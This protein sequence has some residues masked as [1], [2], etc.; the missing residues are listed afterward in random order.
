[1]TSAASGTRPMRSIAAGWQ[2]PLRSAVAA[3]RSARRRRL[4]RP[5]TVRRRACPIVL[6]ARVVGDEKRIRFI[7]DLSAPVDAAVFTLADPYRIIVDLPEV[8][9]ALPE[10][11][12]SRGAGAGLG[13]P[14]RA[15]S[16]RASRASSS[17]SPGR[18]RSTS[19]SS[20]SRPTAS[21]RGW[22]STSCRRRARSFLEASAGLPRQ[23][24]RSR[25][26]KRDRELVA[27][28]ATATGRSIVLDP[29]HGGI[30]TGAKGDGGTLEKDVVLA[31][32]QGA[33]REARRRPAAI[34][35]VYTRNDDSFVALGE[36]VAI[37]R[38]PARRAVRLDPRQFVP[39]GSRC[40]APSSTRSRTRPRTRWPRELAASENQ[41]DALAG[42]DIDGED[43]DQVKD[44]LFDLTR[45]ETRNFGVVFAQNLVKRTRQG[46][47]HVQGSAPGGELQGAGGA[48]RALGA[49]RTRLPVQPDRREAAASRPNGRQKVGR[50][51]GRARSTPTSSKQA[52]RSAG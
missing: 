1:M 33:R 46:D 29:G 24:R 36:R 19:R 9:F 17:T 12:G 16:R 49:D 23:P 45:R 41:S 40:A 31:F 26:A 27:P 43:S 42:I 8:R 13:L 4:R 32:A 10:T 50:L 5:R 44:I 39:G 14:L 11:A 18:W 6:D 51:D 7:A 47:A 37:A 21:R 35:V 30:D 52:G 34:D 25:S 22:S 15:R 3:V 20:S 2:L 48:G 28:A 38:E